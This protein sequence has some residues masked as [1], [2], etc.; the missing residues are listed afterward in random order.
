MEERTI[1]LRDGMF[2]TSL[3]QAGSGDPLLFLHGSPG[4]RQGPY[5]EQLA[6]QFTVYA[7][8][9]P[10]VGEST[11]LDHIDDIVDL[12]LYYYDLM[13]ELGLESAHVVG[14][15]LGGML[16]AEMAALCPHRVRRLVLTNPVG[17]WRDEEPVLDFFT[18][19]AEQLLPYIVHDV[20][21]ETVKQAFARPDSPDAMMEGM[22][23]RMQALTA[24]GK[25]LWPIPDKGLKR[26]I[27]RIQA[28]TLILWGESD[29]LVP[30]SYA[31]DFRSR[32]RD[33]R[34]VILKECAHLPMI[35]KPDEFVSV[36]AEFLNG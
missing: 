28:P 23:Q 10:G 11:G 14:H 32:I 9:H 15:S 5:L 13:D 33:S 36:V 16:G 35:E 18:L 20:E 4:L 19:S 8:L 3:Y 31:E 22:F 24:A 1:S 25:F 6:E 26:R 2:Q 27:H 12:A 17:L 34:V 29:R 30:P 21:S 7:P